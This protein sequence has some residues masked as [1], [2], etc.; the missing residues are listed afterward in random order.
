MPG[1]LQKCTSFPLAQPILQIACPSSLG[2][3]VQWL[4]KKVA[5]KRRRLRLVALKTF[6]RLSKWKRSPGEEPEF[7]MNGWAQPFLNWGPVAFYTA[8]LR[9]FEGHSSEVRLRAQKRI[10]STVSLSL[11]PCEYRILLNPGFLPPRSL[12]ASNW[13]ENLIAYWRL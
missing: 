4:F 1:W 13:P 9:D 2:C 5:S 3:V 11:C 8:P 7:I 6:Q 10:G 12:T